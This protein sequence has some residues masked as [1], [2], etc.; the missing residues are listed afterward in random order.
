MTQTNTDVVQ[1]HSIVKEMELN[2]K[3]KYQ[4]GNELI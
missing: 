1:G 2:G 3:E 4:R